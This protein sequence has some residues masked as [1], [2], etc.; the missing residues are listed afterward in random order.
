MLRRQR[1]HREDAVD[2][3]VGDRLVEQV[4]H[5]VDEDAARALPAQRQRQVFLDQL[6]LASPARAAWRALGEAV[7]RLAW[8]GE[9]RRNRL[10]VAVA[11]TFGDARAASD[12]VPI[13]AIGPLNLGQDSS[14]NGRRGN[15][16]SALWSMRCGSW[17]GMRTPRAGT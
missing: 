16:G 1:H 11:A 2:P 8:I 12:R 5:A 14:P 9:P 7:K 4:A 17:R 3:G 6:N 10:G 13:A 15:G